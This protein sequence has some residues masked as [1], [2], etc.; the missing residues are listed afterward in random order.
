MKKIIEIVSIFLL[1]SISYVVILFILVATV[2]R[3]NT[4]GDGW[5]KSSLPNNYYIDNYNSRNVRIVKEENKRA[6]R[7]SKNHPLE[8]ELMWSWGNDNDSDDEVFFVKELKSE[9]IKDMSYQ[10]LDEY[11]KKNEY[12]DDEIDYIIVDASQDKIYGPYSVEEYQKIIDEYNIRTFH[13]R[14]TYGGG[15]NC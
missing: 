3:Y 2:G 6:K 11:L 5:I 12:K 13:R 8:I 14:R 15:G 10:E 4:D 9:I 1:T 7:I